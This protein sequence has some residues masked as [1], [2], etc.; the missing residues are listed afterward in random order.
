MSKKI[1]SM[2]LIVCMIF[3]MIPGIV[4][5]AE[6]ETEPEK[7][8]LDF[9][10][11]VRQMSEQ[12]W[13]AD[14]AA[15]QTGAGHPARRI[16]SKINTAGMPES[17]Q[18]AYAA[19]RQ[20]LGETQIW[21]I[22]E[23][24]GNFLNP[25]GNRLYFCYDE[26]VD[27]GLSLNNY[28]RGT[29]PENSLSLT[30]QVP[31]S[32]RYD[33][34]MEAVHVVLGSLDFPVDIDI[35][36]TNFGY[37]DIY[38]NGNLMYED[39]CFRGEGIVKTELGPVMLTEGENEITFCCTKNYVGNSNPTPAYH[40]N[41]RS[42]TFT[43]Q[44]V[45]MTHID[46]KQTVREMEQQEWYKDL[47]A[48]KTGNGC[49]ARRIG[50]KINTAGMTETEQQAYAA[51]RQ[52]LDDTQI[53]GLNEENRNFLDPSGNRLYF[54][55]DDAINWGLSWNTYYRGTG[56][57]S[58][59]RMTV[60]MEQAGH[61][62]IS[63]QVGKVVLGSLDFPTDIDIGETNFGYVDVYL[64]GQLLYEDYCFR[65]DGLETVDLGVAYLEKGENEIAF[66]STKCYVGNANPTPA[67]HFNLRAL[68]IMGMSKAKVTE[69]AK[70]NIRLQGGYLPLDA[71]VDPETFTLRVLDESILAASFTEA[72]L[73]EVYG[74]MPGETEVQIF[75][76]GEAV[77]SVPVIVEAADYSEMAPIVMDFKDFAKQAQ[78]Q[79]FWK[80]FRNAVD[81]NTKY[82]GTLN[83][84]DV[85]ST[86]EKAAYNE[87]LAW[88]K[89][90]FDWYIDE[91]LS[92]Y[93]VTG[94]FKRLYINGQDDV[95]WGFS[96]Y[97]YYH[98]KGT[99]AEAA[100]SKF[101]FVVK[102]PCDGWYQL[103]LTTFK[104]NEG[105]AG[106]YGTIGDNSGGDRIAVYVNGEEVIYDYSLV[107]LNAVAS[108]NMGAVYLKEGENS[109]VVDSLLSFNNLPVAGRSNV[110]LISM[111]FTPLKGVQVQE[112]LSLNLDLRASYFHYNA[113]VS[114]LSVEST[115]DQI[116]SAAINAG[117][118]ITMNGITK[119][120]AKVFVKRGDT[121]LTIVP[122][123]VT[124][125]EG[126]LD[127]LQ[128]SPAK[129]D[130]M[131]FADR[132]VMQ[133]WWAGENGTMTV[134]ADHTAVTDWL[135]DNG[136]WDLTEGAM[137]VSDGS[138]NYGIKISDEAVIAVDIP[139]SGLYNMTVEYL[140]GGKT[141]RIC[142]NGETVCEDLD[143][144][145]QEAVEKVSL[146][147]VDLAK[148]ENMVQIA[149][150]EVMLRAVTFTPLGTVTTEKG[151]STQ[152]DLTNTY[153]ASH[154]TASA[155][156]AGNAAVLELDGN[157]AAIH[158]AAVGE[159]VLTVTGSKTY[160]VPVKVLE[161]SDLDFITY[162]ADGFKAETLMVGQTAE[163]ILS[164]KTV[165]GVKLAEQYLC[166]TANV[167][168]ST[169]DRNVVKVDAVS[170]DLTAVAEGSAVVS[171]YVMLDGVTKKD[172]V[173]IAVTDDTDLEAI[174]IGTEVSF[175]ATGNLLQLY[176]SG[177][178]ASGA[179][180]DM[181]KFPVNW[182]VDDE[183]LATVS[184]K[185]VVTGLCEGTVTVTATA[186]VNGEPVSHAVAILVVDDAVLPTSDIL[187]E[188][189]E[190]RSLYIPELTLERDGVELDKE[191]T[192]K[193]GE[194]MSHDGQGIHHD[195]AAGKG[196]AF[197]F[198]A[199]QSGWYQ[200]YIQGKQ[201]AS[202][203]GM[204]H[205]Y[206][207]GQ[208]MGY[209]E[210]GKNNGNF[211]AGGRMD[212]IY[213]E[214]GVHHLNIVSLGETRIM[215]GR[216]IF[217]PTK[218]PG[219]V[220][221]AMDVKDR[222]VV[223]ETA[224]VT[225]TMHDENAQK[226]QLL[227]QSKDPGHTNY[228]GVFSSNASV[229]SVSG[230][231]L[232]ARKA[233]TATI[234][235]RGEANG[236][237]VEKSVTVT[238]TGG[239]VADAALSAERTT[240]K[241][242]AEPFD[243]ALTAYDA[244]GEAI[245]LPAG[246][247]VTYESSN[248]AILTVDANGHVTIVGGQGSA[249]VTATVN[250]NGNAVTAELWFSV[251]AAKTEPTVY[252]YEERANAQ[253]NA[254]KYSWAWSM[255]ETAVK[256]A[257]FYVEHLDEI[258]DMWIPG[259]FPRSS[260]V[261]FRSDPA[262]GNCRYCG[263]YLLDRFGVYPWLV[264]PIN[265]PW[266][267]T[268]PIC[269]H[270]FPSNDFGSY[271]Y[272]GLD[273]N[274][275]F[276]KELADPQYLKNELYPEM[277]EGWG[278]DDGWGFM[279]TSAGG[280][281]ECHTYIAYYL[282]VW[283][284]GFAG[285]AECPDTM[286]QI[287]P[288]LADAY[289]YTGDEKYGSA[290]AILLDRLADI[291]PTYDFYDMDWLNYNFVCALS[292]HGRLIGITWDAVLGI[293]FARVV[294]VFWPSANNEDVIDYLRERASSQGKD[295][296]DI[297]PDYLRTKAEDNILMELYEMSKSQWIDGNFGMSEAAVAYSA[298]ALNRLPISQEMVD[299]IYHSEELTGS[300]RDTKNAGGDV[301]RT[302]VEWTSRDGLA[303]EG[304]YAYNSIMEGYL[305]D[306]ADALDGFDLVEGADLWENQKFVNLYAGHM[307]MTVCGRLTPQIHEGGGPQSTNFIPNIGYMTTA[308]SKS[309]DPQIARALYA[310][311][312]N[313][314]DGLH[315]DIF[316]KNPESGL[317]TAIQNAVDTY[318]TW[319]MSDS[320]LLPGYGIAILREGPHD[321]LGMENAHEFSDYWIGFGYSD[322]DHA[323]VES[324]N[325]D[326]EFHGL[327]LSSSMG[328]PT[329]VQASSH[330]R[331][332]W[333]RNTIS[334]NTVVVDDKAQV[335]TDEAGFPLHFEDAGYAKVMDIE[336]SKAY[337]EADIYRR[338]FVAVDNG[339]G[340]HYGVDFF[341]VLGGS[342]HV[343]SFHGMTDVDPETTGLELAKQ[344]MGS[345]AGPEI[346]YGD[347]EISGT[348]DAIL[349]TGSGYS[350]LDDVYRDAEP[351]T[352]FTVD[353]AIKDFRHRLAT[354]D[355]IH[356][357]LTM[358]SEEPMTEVALANGYPPK[359]STN[360]M[361]PHMEY[362]L[363]RRSGN[364][365]MDTLFTT[366]IE[367]YQ[368]NSY[369]ASSELV[370][371][372]LLE[373]TE[374]ITDK[375]A[376]VKVTLKSGRVDYIVYA[377]NPDC[378]YRVAD[379]F[380]FMGFAG[381]VS[382]TDGQITYAWGNE[383][384]AVAD[385]VEDARPSV[386]GTVTDFTKDITRDGYFMTITMDEPATSAELTGRWIYVETDGIENGAYR[387]FGAEVKDD[388]AVLEL[389]HQTLVRDYVDK[390]DF[391]KGYKYNIDEGASFVIPLSAS[392]DV[393]DVLNHTTDQVVKVGSKQTLTL[394]KAGS[395]AT[396][397]VEGLPTSA[398]VDA[399]TGTVTWTPSRTQTGR[400]PVTVKAMVDG[401]TVGEMSF[402]IY[403]VSYTG[404]SYE[405]SKCNHAKAVSFEADGMIETVCPACGTVTKTEAPLGK[406]AFVGSN[407][408]LGNE[409]KLNFMVNT[410][411]LKDGYT[412]LITHKG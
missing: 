324:L 139:A 290:G 362:M 72:G 153:L 174:T 345:Y 308:F 318:G 109:V 263:E 179:A 257:D 381:V 166:E 14:L 85:L 37:V 315:A 258:Y 3:G 91:G 146:G 288:T 235:V 32:G 143:T 181:S 337:P 25:S 1:I 79:S 311:N 169:S 65:G 61:Y 403:V 295:P 300:G 53:W 233:G 144:A 43:K 408:T 251:N 63:M 29:D 114:G 292:G 338:T 205:V 183:T 395:G 323:Q 82:V 216:A 67:W 392:F 34:S 134:T 357:K 224:E 11:T 180:A 64:N 259:Y 374:G 49:D 113:D 286:F 165:N 73:L 376:A 400:Y 246:T 103:D 89:E 228:Y 186:V 270:D 411:D 271:Y 151:R 242:D 206:V 344:G 239:T 154:E 348:S 397:A 361:V 190:G 159:A 275:E 172:S 171:V 325:L 350:W 229:V 211:G 388:T 365:D 164:A 117:G 335:P 225:L 380:D 104:E 355:G 90:N 142:V 359:K 197:Y 157:V 42:L 130:F 45:E 343:Y 341:R 321:Y 285:N 193:G 330:E 366:V 226:W 66:C 170:G 244:A 20:W 360:A 86:E 356:L 234:T 33:I 262:Y 13:Y 94:A 84:Y 71:V 124:G 409:L 23:K 155:S 10:E 48:V 209:M 163:G 404:S 296:E 152:L 140:A 245:E 354:T 196:L 297:T 281:A 396:Y 81:E 254:K 243:L 195:G 373:G 75:E 8:V 227:L 177:T 317:R 128:G 47:P 232:T 199:R 219:T 121:I 389:R 253:E 50:S 44:E 17:E 129:V 191:N 16:G 132:A 54:C 370:N 161:K 326:I 100:N 267:I 96:G 358:M 299:W 382:Y 135:A 24:R 107:G 307:R 138:A 131:A 119:G 210:N 220:D 282:G 329:I 200:L 353:W 378:L 406:F 352:T 92:M 27:W 218:D 97:T 184:D 402:V 167:Y 126:A 214:A 51:M 112:Y 175:V 57:E 249:K 40:F 269:K 207:D 371:V 77:C 145:G 83:Y 116:V 223:G 102:A 241:P 247:E 398:K 188:F 95:P 386:T 268:C 198:V 58:T 287:L 133:S 39:Y 74:L 22:N 136:R 160:T 238:V 250:E 342:E 278:V 120:N 274:G 368:Y 351:D 291:Y 87:M 30:V 59:L 306:V 340:D 283:M 178:K 31:Q 331:Q 41:L 125:F 334:H 150:S 379:L 266:K 363:V 264:D 399:K 385:V 18:Q 137:T 202:V 52:W 204:N 240:F 56:A 217:Y 15:V 304:S 99:P 7:I 158:G 123:E 261:G 314:T 80:E 46:F 303:Y 347:W 148:G 60:E 390:M 101:G 322:T 289:L 26:D 2:L 260:Q 349:N 375:A 6:A 301:A 248:E 201:L 401:E 147:A 5:A 208:F 383:A 203:G 127:E 21:N 327:G 364:D 212:T 106:I 213:L 407:M 189:D 141:A 98:G 394:G 185:G 252:T 284:S 62:N 19:M 182:E 9:K 312:G 230:A 273:E 316:T 276:H 192:N 88:N 122:V 215:L 305:L 70:S 222:L 12:D 231:A 391:S 313:S 412:A 298:R 336:D 319:D 294:D 346:P 162:T 280:N 38:V 302:L 176:V 293:E 78:Q 332:Q 256:K 372:E 328:Y 339:E 55:S 194:G 68:T 309:G 108:D 236:Q 369:V 384:T 69:E 272:S 333:V 105:W 110:P 320:D 255:K 93:S 377:T 35:A 237:A 168:Y 173:T 410:S 279:T 393:S 76:N 149:A 115:N 277:G 310:A 367:P 221:I 387:I 111:V 265:N 405:A 118:V 156:L 187:L 36:E 4:S 28:Y